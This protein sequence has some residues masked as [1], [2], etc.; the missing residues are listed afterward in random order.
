MLVTS[1]LLS[2]CEAPFNAI[3]E[4]PVTVGEDIL[5]FKTTPTA[6]PVTEKTDEPTPSVSPT[7][8]AKLIP[9]MT[10]LT[11]TPTPTRYID[12][13]E[14]VVT[15]GPTNTP[16]ATA[17]PTATLAPSVTSAVS[18]N[19][20]TPTAAPTQQTVVTLPPAETP[21]ATATPTP[22]LSPEP[23]SVVIWGTSTPVPSPTSA[24]F[25]MPNV[26]GYTY[27]DAVTLLRT[28]APGLKISYVT[29]PSSQMTQGHVIGQYPAAGSDALTDASVTLTVAGKSTKAPT[30]TPKPTA[31]PTPAPWYTFKFNGEAQ[32]TKTEKTSVW[33]R[34]YEWYAD[35]S[36]FLKTTYSWG[37]VYIEVWMPEDENAE[38]R[39]IKKGTQD[40]DHTTHIEFYD[41]CSRDIDATGKITDYDE[42][43]KKVSGK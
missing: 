13:N 15:Y 24:V 23:T 34:Y 29:D 26:N 42:K 38:H 37:G 2:G 17:K 4:E 33:T 14:Y 1:F 8:R 5:M 39:G 36:T 9:D 27:D 41:G 3:K 28:L 11:P 30:A 12:G 7:E 20:S 6:V 25:R 35:T 16:G 21:K 19:P 32:R 31:T 10:K 43:G 40:F 18:A 22:S